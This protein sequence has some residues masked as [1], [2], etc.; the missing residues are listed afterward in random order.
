MDFADGGPLCFYFTT[1]PG[2][3]DYTLVGFTPEECSSVT[4]PGAV[5]RSLMADDELDTDTRTGIVLL[6]T[7]FRAR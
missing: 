5:S 4:N 1:A 2:M 7:H 3:E 6:A